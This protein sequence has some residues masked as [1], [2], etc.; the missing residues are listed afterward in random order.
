MIQHQ[1][2]GLLVQ[3]ARHEELAWAI[4]HLLGSEE[5]RKRLGEAGRLR[6]ETFSWERVATQVLA[7]YEEVRGAALSESVYLSAEAA[8]I[9]LAE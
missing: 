4:C 5:E 3:P 6:A 8:T 2:D 7:F 9:S 1:R